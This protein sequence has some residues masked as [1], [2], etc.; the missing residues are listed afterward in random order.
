[1]RGNMTDTSGRTIEIPI[2]SNLREGMN[3]LEFFI[4]SHGARKA[5]SDTAL[6]TADSG[7]LTRR[8]V[9]V[10]QDVIIRESDC[11]T[12]EYTVMY[13]VFAG[14]T[15]KAQRLVRPLWERITG[16][17][18]AMD[19]LH[20]ETGELLFSPTLSNPNVKNP[21]YPGLITEEDA[22]RI[23]K[24][25]VKSV[26]IRS[27][28]TCRARYGIC[29]KCYGDNLANREPAAGGEAVGIMAAQSIGEPGTQLTM[30]TFHTG[31]IA[32]GDDITQGLPRVEELFE[33]RKPKGYAIVS[34]TAGTVR[35]EET[36]KR[37]RDVVVTSA[38]G[39]LTRTPISYGAPLLVK[40][41]D[42]VSAGSLITEGPVNPHDIMKHQGV[43]GV[44]HYIIQEVLK[45]Y[46]NNGVDINDKHVEIITRQMMRKVR[47]DDPGDTELLT[48][49]IVDMY[50]F[51]EQNNRAETEGLL[52][53]TG[54][55]VL[56]GIT[57]ASLA[58]DSFLSAAS[59]QETTR[60]LTDA[61][62]KG[63][64]DPLLGL[65]ENV[66]IGKLIPAGTGMMRYRNIT[67]VPVVEENRHLIIT[68]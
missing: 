14:G 10:A 3:V 12:K 20:P 8:L 68:D 29:A 4:S 55:R 41:G 18:A 64:V 46:K 59:F 63:K 47:V 53:A 48:G 39:T 16:R 33:A 52:P 31:G 27:V 34:E 17:Y 42:V 1:M 36:T 57:K 30:R 13:D 58:T 9:D 32:S 38:D 65:K 54:K 37:R 7:Y 35:I 15:G 51:E 6:K 21:K 24:A 62:V 50:D 44:Q 56:L 40:D 11:G 2:K 25:G 60:V 26:T 5:L 22:E 66:I 67:A 23:S 61:A 43:P 49:S 28:L 19:V 45:V